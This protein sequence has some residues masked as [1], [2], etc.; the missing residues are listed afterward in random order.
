MLEVYQKTILTRPN[1]REKLAIRPTISLNIFFII[2]FLFILFLLPRAVFAFSSPVINEIAWMG[3]NSS[4]SNE[5]IELFNNSSSSI[6]LSGWTLSSEDK[7]I[8]I[9]LVGEIQAYGFFL[10]ERT[11]DSSVLNITADQ[12]YTG[13]LSNNG[14]NLILL[15]K[16]GY[17]ADEINCL[18]GWPTGDNSTKQ[19]MERT[20]S[21]LETKDAE[22]QTSETSEGSPKKPNSLFSI[23]K[24]EELPNQKEAEVFLQKV[25][26]KKVFLNEF[27][28]SPEGPD[29]KNEWIEL[30]NQNDFAVDLSGWKLSDIVGTTKIYSFP[31]QTTIQ[32]NGFL[33]FQ[34]TETN[35]TLNNSGDVVNLLLPN[36]TILESVS[37]EKAEREESYA[38]NTFGAWEWSQ[39][40]SPGEINT[41]NALANLENKAISETKNQDV[42]EKNKQNIA[43]ISRQYPR[44]EYNP[45]IAL[46]ALITALSSVTIILYLKSKINPK[47]R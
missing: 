24:E 15:N 3:T 19:T 22:W 45:P 30:F 11:D 28:P 12:I 41:L 33:V 20:V 26:S 14:E 18:Q 17:K 16:Q 42:L 7:K 21:S 8:N 23:T 47:I 4:Y 44:E 37:Y 38:K 5:W 46:P 43:T 39:N 31:D 6:N 13:S 40:P 25:Y 35:I 27:L 34:R 36:N 32:A 2:F 9:F 10:L 1:T 29:N